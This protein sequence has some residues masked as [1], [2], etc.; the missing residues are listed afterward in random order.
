MG[1]VGDQVR[2]FM[3][4]Q[5][6]EAFRA[7]EEGKK[8]KDE[9]SYDAI[10]YAFADKG[11]AASAI[12]KM[13]AALDKGDA[14]AQADVDYSGKVLQRGDAAL[15]SIKGALSLNG[16]WFA[17]FRAPP[18]MEKI[19]RQSVETDPSIKLLKQDPSSVLVASKK[20]TPANLKETRVEALMRDPA[21][22]LKSLSATQRAKLRESVK[23]L[24]ESRPSERPAAR[25]ALRA[26]AR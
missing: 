7:L 26:L 17:Y 3:S 24:A 4:L 11:S 25:K 22:Y 19:V 10:V 20:Q 1:E 5:R 9:R 16:E 6:D 2:R 12:A 8:A 18:E 21:A 23:K 14:Q 15:G 13:K